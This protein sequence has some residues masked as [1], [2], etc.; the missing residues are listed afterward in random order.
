MFVLGL[1]DRGPLSA[2]L[3]LWTAPVIVAR[4]LF[5]DEEKSLHMVFMVLE[6]LAYFLS[7]ILVTVSPPE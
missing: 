6:N 4:D 7:Q 3:N 5:R 1:K 2:S